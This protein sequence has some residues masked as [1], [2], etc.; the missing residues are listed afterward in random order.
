MMYPNH[1]RLLAA[2]RT[3]DHSDLKVLVL[4]KYSS[5]LRT[6]QYRSIICYITYIV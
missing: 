5:A 6:D 2:K 1:Q 4:H 3:G